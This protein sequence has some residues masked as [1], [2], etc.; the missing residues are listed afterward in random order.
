MAVVGQLNA[1][2]KEYMT[3]CKVDTVVLP[4]PYNQVPEHSNYL[5]GSQVSTHVPF[6]CSTYSTA[7]HAR[8]AHQLLKINLIAWTFTLPFVIVQET[9]WFCPYAPPLTKHCPPHAHRR[10][11]PRT[12]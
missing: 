5:V 11:G 10:T 3:L 6:D 8:A 2:I 1:L 9:G 12:C 4:M 7:I